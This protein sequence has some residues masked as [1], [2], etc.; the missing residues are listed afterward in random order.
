M[1]KNLNNEFQARVAKS[2]T[3]F[4]SM[5]KVNITISNGSGNP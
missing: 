3:F 5:T 4:I 2:Y 1:H